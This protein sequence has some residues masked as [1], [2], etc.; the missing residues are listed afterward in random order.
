M[1]YYDIQYMRPITKESE[2]S[3][4]DKKMIEF[5]NSIKS[6]SLRRIL[7]YYVEDKC[8]K[9]NPYYSVKH[10]KE[11]FKEYERSKSDYYFLPKMNERLEGILKMLLDEYKY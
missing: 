10:L 4:K 7:R 11:D 9:E 3:I 5:L 1:D 2:T 6:T 8:Y